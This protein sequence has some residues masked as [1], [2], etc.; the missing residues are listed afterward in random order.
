M[1]AEEPAVPLTPAQA[2]TRHAYV[3]REIDTIRRC[4]RERK[5]PE[6][7]QEACPEFAKQF[8]K[9]FEKLTNGEEYNES[10]L[11]TLLVMLERMGSGQ[12]S[13][14]EASQIVGQRMVDTY[15]KPKLD[16]AGT[17]GNTQ[18]PN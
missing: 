8:P 3:M 13:Q 14:H 12:L 1:P 10:S 16:Q 2:R 17:G 7:I 18:P 5:S 4:L 11:R 9:L 15:I 6:E